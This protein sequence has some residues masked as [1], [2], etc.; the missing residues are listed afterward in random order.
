MDFIVDL[1]LPS[2]DAGV[3]AQLVLVIVSLGF[4]LWRFWRDPD[5]RLVVIGSGLLVLGF[6]GFRALH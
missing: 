5:I 2:T 6:I 1:L 4:A 3:A